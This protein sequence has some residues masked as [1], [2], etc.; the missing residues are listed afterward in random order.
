M[1]FEQ[2]HI[3]LIINLCIQA[4]D[5]EL[6]A[7]DCVLPCCTDRILQYAQSRTG[8]TSSYYTAP[9]HVADKPTAPIHVLHIVESV[10]IRL[11]QIYEIGMTLKEHVFALISMNDNLFRFANGSDSITYLRLATVVQG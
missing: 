2:L 3:F 10:L 9:V 6:K 4:P 5:M 1:P 8:Q 7:M 11:H